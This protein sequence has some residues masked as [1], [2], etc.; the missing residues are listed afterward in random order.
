[1]ATI[2]LLL[3]LH[4]EAKTEYKTEKADCKELT[5]G[6]GQWSYNYPNNAS[7]SAYTGMNLLH[8]FSKTTGIPH[9]INPDTPFARQTNE[10][11]SGYLDAIFGLYAI[12]ERLEL[13]DFSDEYYREPLYIY[14]KTSEAKPPQSLDDLHDRLGIVIR[15]A[16]YG[17]LID[18][19]F[20]E[21][22]KRPIIVN[23]HSL[24]L[25]MLIGN[26]GDYLIGSELGQNKPLIESGLITRSH[27]PVGW[28]GV[29][30]GF[31]KKSP[32]RHWIPELNELIKNRIAST[33]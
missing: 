9:K 25:T 15:G 4:T 31:S 27:L 10:L 33:Q 19:F 30:V 20:S 26:R 32:C 28:V 13:F 12:P 1:L 5:V 21:E 17:P 23:K 7:I 22:T 6:G 16:S 11:K 14:T 18:R 2:S 3:P 29:T 24:R 8:E